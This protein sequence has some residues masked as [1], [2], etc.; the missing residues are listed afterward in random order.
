MRSLNMF[1]DETQMLLHV[2]SKGSRSFFFYVHELS[3]RHRCYYMFI[4]LDF[5][6]HDSP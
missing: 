5:R 4:V 3:I 2:Y 1:S 6:S